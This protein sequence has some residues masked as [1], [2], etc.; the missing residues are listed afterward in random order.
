MKKFEYSRTEYEVICEEC[1]FSEEERIILKMRCTG[2]TAQEILNVLE[3]KDKPMS[4]A[5]LSRK[6]LKIDNRIKKLIREK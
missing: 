3:E 6:I 5:T 2:K 1:M 4:T